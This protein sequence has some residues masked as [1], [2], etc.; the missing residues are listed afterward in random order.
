MRFQPWK[1]TSGATRVDDSS[2]GS[3][4]QLV[5][6]PGTLGQALVPSEGPN[7]IQNS[8]R[9]AATSGMF[10]LFHRKKKS[11]PDDVMAVNIPQR[12]SRGDWREVLGPDFPAPNERSASL[13]PEPP[14]QNC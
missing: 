2:R 6:K 8:T 3:S 14:D 1:A 7:R 9:G 10:M 13:G 11:G 12:T 5:P 4:P